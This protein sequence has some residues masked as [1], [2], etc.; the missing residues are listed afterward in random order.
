MTPTILKTMTSDIIPIFKTHGSLGKSILTSWSKKDVGE[1]NWPIS[2]SGPVSVVGIAE[3]HNLENVVVI[4]DTFL[5]FPSLYKN[6]KKSKLIFGVNFDC[7]KNAL[8][9]SEDSLKTEHKIS[10]VMKNGNG[11]RDLLK[12]H[13][14]VH[15]NQNYF[16][17]KTR[18]D[19]DVIKKNWTDNL[20]LIVPPYDNFIHK[21]LLTNSVCVPDFGPIKPIM[22]FARM[23][24]P[25]DYL[26]EDNI[27][28][29]A[30]NNG[31]EL[32]EVH[33]VYYYKES[34]VK[35][36]YAFKCIENRTTF[37]EPELEFFTSNSFSW[38]SYLNKTN[39]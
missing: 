7:C 11:Y 16:Y 27:K 26:L 8:E 39:A 17:Y 33:P 28:R 9:K 34:D 29:Y 12:I 23:N 22:T 31:F 3:K 24:L 14:L 32:Q 1:E 13:N 15:T 36:F 25:F 38:E 30:E 19:F 18:I 6:L 35:A 21:N 5:S 4:D 10:V 37:A 2:E 20:S